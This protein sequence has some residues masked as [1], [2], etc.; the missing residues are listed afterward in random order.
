MGAITIKTNEHEQA[1]RKTK[2]P[3]AIIKIILSK[4]CQKIKTL[5]TE[6]RDLDFEKHARLETK[7]SMYT[8]RRDLF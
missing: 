7:R 6:T 3:F 5:S 8:M 1:S 2:K 4:L